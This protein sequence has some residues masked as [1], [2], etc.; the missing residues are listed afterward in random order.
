MTV[1]VGRRGDASLTRFFSPFASRSLLSLNI[2]YSWWMLATRGLSLVRFSVTDRCKNEAI[3]S[4]AIYRQKK[5]GGCSKFWQVCFHCDNCTRCRYCS[6]EATCRR[7]VLAGKGKPLCRWERPRTRA[8]W[9]VIAGE[10]QIQNLRVTS[11]V[12]DDLCDATGPLVAPTEP[13]PTKC[14]MWPVS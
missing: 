2:L 4:S 6:S 11:S 13:V 10:S 3:F 1:S 9:E 8:F 7:V 14:I 12:F 5:N